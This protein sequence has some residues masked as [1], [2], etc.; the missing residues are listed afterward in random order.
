[1]TVRILE[2]RLNGITPFVST[3]VENSGD[4]LVHVYFNLKGRATLVCTSGD[5][6]GS[7]FDVVSRHG[8]EF[9]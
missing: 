1:M 4:Q 5:S 6:K 3:V 8:G 7:P 9:E 2:I